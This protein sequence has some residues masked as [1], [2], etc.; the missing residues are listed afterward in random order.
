MKILSKI[1]ILLLLPVSTFAQ[2]TINGLIINNL[3]Q[4][5]INGVVVK[6]IVNGKM[7]AYNVSANGGKFE[8]KFNSKSSELL[9]SFEHM[10]YSTVQKTILN[11]PQTLKIFLTEKAFEI[12]EVTV[13]AP[14]LSQRGDTISYRLAAFTGKGDISL[15]DA[16]KNLPGITVTSN[17]TVQYLGKEINRFYIEGMD[18]L[19]GRYSIATKGLP[20]TAVSSVEVMENHQAIKQLR[21]RIYSD[22]VAINLKLSQKAKLKPFGT[23]EA[24]TGQGEEG[25]LYRLGLTGMLFTPKF[26]LISTAKIGNVGALGSS[27]VVSH[28][29]ENNEI[30][31]KPLSIV[32][33]MGSNTPPLNERRYKSI[34]DRMLSVNTIKKLSKEAV[35]KA[36]TDYAYNENSYSNQTVSS[37]YTSEGNVVVNEYISPQKKVHNPALALEYELNDSTVYIRNRLSAKG[38]FEN[39]EF[40]I[41][42]AANQINQTRK[43]TSFSI[44]N[45]FDFRKRIGEHLWSFSSTF[46][47]IMT[48]K[49]R[50][51]FSGVKNVQGEFYQLANGNTFFTNEEFN[52]RLK[53]GEYVRIY[54]PFSFQ[55]TVDNL[56]TE[57]V[58]S[59]STA[60]NSI[61]GYQ[62]LP[63]VSPQLEVNSPSNRLVFRLNL[64]IRYYLLNYSN[65]HLKFNKVTIDPNIYLNYTL[66]PSSKIQLTAGHSNE[67]GDLLDLLT[68]PIQVNYR[69]QNIKSG[70]IA[71]NQTDFATLKMEYKRPLDFLFINAQ[72]GYSN[73]KRNLLFSQ[74][75][76]N[77]NIIN[78]TIPS[79]NNSQSVNSYLT[80]TKLLQSLKTKITIGGS[81]QWSKGIL[82]QQAVVTTFRQSTPTFLGN[83]TSR[84]WSWVELDYAARVS[85][86]T[87]KF[88]NLS[89]T[90]PSQTHLT[91]LSFF[92][93]PKMQLF[94]KLEFVQNKVTTSTYKDM[95]LFDIGGSF[96]LKSIRFGIAVNNLLNSK[97]YSYTIFNGLD[98][99][100]NS[101][102][103]RGREFLLSI[104]FME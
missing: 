78:T 82:T 41:N 101:Y 34:K 6:A 42:N 64:P 33:D 47:Y 61:N 100:S 27:E 20:A 96:K 39:N 79:D 89:Q 88:S 32:G 21:N 54:S 90:L 25:F 53:I 13:S 49:N 51:T 2:T 62:L 84:P 58:K 75:I 87:S 68:Q 59:T 10:T 43:A 69:A 71:Q 77:E 50:L 56:N 97:Q 95:A 9:I 74:I 63:S 73:L 37:Y 70:I 46:G 104:I 76:T 44:N 92:P 52:F 38:R 7:V 1:F 26:Q 35:L 4:Q 23:S 102:P 28:F 81:Y 12:K 94:S 60:L 18:M 91:K 103:L 8:L 80:I 45:N 17:G 16:L 57:L 14:K 86:I 24:L 36:N 83:L 3:N 67:V 55:A 65:M 98:S 30:F 48:P 31:S 19:G 72:V 22:N 29:K 5:G 11:Q 15:E 99:F 93:T 85:W 40:L 66:S